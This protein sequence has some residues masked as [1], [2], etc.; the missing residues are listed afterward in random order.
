MAKTLLRMRGK[1]TSNVQEAFMY[2]EG[3]TKDG[4]N[5]NPLRASDAYKVII[6]ALLGT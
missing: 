2:L 5:I 6:D 4:K 3:K 1:F